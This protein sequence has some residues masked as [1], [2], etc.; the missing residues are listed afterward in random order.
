MEE[1]DI[2]EAIAL[3]QEFHVEALEV[4]GI[5]PD[6]EKL[7]Q[8]ARVFMSTSFVVVADGKVVGTLVGF[9]TEYVGGTQALYQEVMW[10]MN[11]RYRKYGIQLLR[12]VEEWCVENG[13]FAIMMV[14][15]GSA[16]GRLHDFFLRCGYKTL[17]TQYMKTLGV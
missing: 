8:M 3:V 12:K 2:A 9:I 11:K 6:K 15:L 16:E 7:Q 5:Y 14:G 10:F 1:R 13:I 4:I 17:E